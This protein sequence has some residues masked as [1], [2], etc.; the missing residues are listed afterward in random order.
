MEKHL[1]ERVSPLAA[2][3][4]EP[5]AGD[6]EL[7]ASLPSAVRQR[8]QSQLEPVNLRVGQVLCDA[9]LS[10][11]HVY[12]PTT[13][14]VSLI[15]PM[16]DGAS[17]EIAV[18]GRDGMVGMTLLMGGRHVLDASGGAQCRTGLPV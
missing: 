18:I 7:L 1:M 8:W 4:L 13:A 10:P 15:C 16:R 14:M 6:N 11:R 17:T 3:P 12:F 5:G 2:P 9:G